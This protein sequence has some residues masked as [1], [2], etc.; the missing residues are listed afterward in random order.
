MTRHLQIAI[1]AGK[2][3]CRSKLDGPWC[4]FVRYHMA[5]GTGHCLL[6][7][8]PLP[9]VAPDGTPVEMGWL[10]RLPECKAAEVGDAS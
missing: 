1:T 6:F 9:E 8:K 5:H 7:N 4:Q 2:H 10:G 3:T